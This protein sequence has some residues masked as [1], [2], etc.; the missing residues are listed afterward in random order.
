VPPVAEASVEFGRHLAGVCMGC[1]QSDLTGGPVPGGDPS[2]PPA[3]DLTLHAGG[4][5]TYEQFRTVMR[6]SR[7]PD[8]TALRP[9]MDMVT[10]YTSRM[11]DTELEALWAYLQSLPPSA[12]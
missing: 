1:H 10:G 3:A 11:S 5:W 9:P 2:W 8:G 6:E 4:D 7:R 12:S